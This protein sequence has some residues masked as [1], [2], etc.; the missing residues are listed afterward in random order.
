MWKFDVYGIVAKIFIL[1]G[2][3]ILHSVMFDFFPLP[4]FV[5]SSWIYLGH[6]KRSAN[7]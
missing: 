6:V 2:C 5:D 3:E 1:V 7:Q 4:V